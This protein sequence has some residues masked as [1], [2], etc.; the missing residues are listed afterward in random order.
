MNAI[1]PIKERLGC[2]DTLRLQENCVEWCMYVIPLYQAAHT[3]QEH[4]WPNEVPGYENVESWPNPDS[5]PSEPIELHQGMLPA[6]KK[7]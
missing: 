7:S 1:K 6:S 2:L 5:M 3:M 4:A